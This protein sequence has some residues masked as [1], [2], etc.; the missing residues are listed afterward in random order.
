[1]RSDSLADPQGPRRR[2]TSGVLSV[3]LSENEN[4]L[5][6]ESLVYLEREKSNSFSA[7]ILLTPILTSN[8]IQEASFATVMFFTPRKGSLLEDM[9]GLQFSQHDLQNP[10]SRGNLLAQN[11]V[12]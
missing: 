10:K 9:K 11:I 2:R 12:N 4:D 7:A 5:S 8:D 3:S 1:M 6:W